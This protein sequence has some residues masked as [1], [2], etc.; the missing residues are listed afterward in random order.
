MIPNRHWSL[1]LTRLSKK[2]IPTL[3]KKPNVVKE[4]ITPPLKKKKIDTFNK[5]DK[6]Q[7]SNKTVDT[8]RRNKSDKGK[9]L[10]KSRSTQ[11]T[12]KNIFNTVNK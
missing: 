7:A 11:R 6:S 4:S 9:S 3:E 10:D 2:V 1:L 12:E 5:T 8:S